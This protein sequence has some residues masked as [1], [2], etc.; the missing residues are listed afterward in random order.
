MVGAPVSEFMNRAGAFSGVGC[1]INK[2][3]R[4]RDNWQRANRRA[5]FAVVP[6]TVVGID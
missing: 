5:F 4:P 6:A 3:G 1:R 2:F